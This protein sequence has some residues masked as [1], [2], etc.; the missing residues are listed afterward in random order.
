MTFQR[1]QAIKIHAMLAFSLWVDRGYALAFA[2][3][4]LAFRLAFFD[5][6]SCSNLV[7][8]MMYFLEHSHEHGL[9]GLRSRRTAWVHGPN[10]SGLNG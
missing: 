5:K 4:A 9:V 7:K 3:R 8:A 10:V 1:W 6:K 2:S